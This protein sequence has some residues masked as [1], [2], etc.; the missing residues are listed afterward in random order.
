MCE[1]TGKVGRGQV[2]KASEC[3]AE[4]LVF[5]PG[6]LLSVWDRDD[7]RT[8]ILGRSLEQLSGER[9]EAAKPTPQPA[10]PLPQQLLP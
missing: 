6:C 3:Q 8:H 5:D 10:F 2:V 1:K 9:L 7:A 4:D